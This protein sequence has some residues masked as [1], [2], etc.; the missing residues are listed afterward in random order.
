M[1]AVMVGL[2]AC[3]RAESEAGTS[4][5]AETTKK[6]QI[7]IDLWPGYFPLL[8]ADDLGYL[9]KRGVEVEVSVPQDTHRM[10]ADFAGGRY[11]AICVSMG[12]LV[13]AYPRA[14][15]I[16]MI[17]CSDESAGADQVIGPEAL[18]DPV[19]LFGKRIGTTVGGFGELLVRRFV[20]SRGLK[21]TD[22]T[23][24]NADAAN[25][26]RLLKEKQIDAAHTWEPYA[27]EA[28]ASGYSLLFSSAEAPGLILDGL[29]VHSRSITEDR[30]RMQA[31]VLAWFEAVEWWKQNPEQAEHRLNRVFTR[32]ALPARPISTE[33]ILIHDAAANR[34]LFSRGAEGGLEKSA[35]EF[36]RF[37]SERGSLP[38][39]PDPKALIDGS[40]I[41]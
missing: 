11:D 17:L 28:R 7:A 13:L 4:G 33:G 25:G 5:G 18:K 6:I 15:E 20:A 12:D 21:P 24:V 16:R 32:L 1:L 34:K 26:L 10:I 29:V 38:M 30:E 31:L 35:L 41:P 9:G 3:K 37:F 39:A 2:S 14:R 23:L 22:I 36:I 27:T 19:Q 8:L 40:L